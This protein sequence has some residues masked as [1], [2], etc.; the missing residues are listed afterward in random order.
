MIVISLIIVLAKTNPN[1]LFSI[2]ISLFKSTS[3]LVLLLYIIYSSNFNT[4]S[5]LAG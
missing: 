3:K 2:F 4:L 5:I 1:I